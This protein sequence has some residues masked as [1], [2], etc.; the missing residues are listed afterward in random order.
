MRIEP[1]RATN[2]S[3]SGDMVQNQNRPESVLPATAVQEVNSQ[4]PTANSNPQR[5]GAAELEQAVDKMNRALGAFNHA[6]Q[7]EVTKSKRIVVRVIDTNTGEI[8]RQ[9]PPEELLDSFNR[10]Q[11]AIGVLIDRRV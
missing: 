5:D 6:L 4:R 9:I 7:F 10:M 11:D 8:I 2:A 1:N 3:G